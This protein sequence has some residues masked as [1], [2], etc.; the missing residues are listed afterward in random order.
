MVYFKQVYAINITDGSDF[1]LTEEYLSNNTEKYKKILRSR[2]R[3]LILQGHRLDKVHFKHRRV[4]GRFTLNTRSTERARHK[5][6][7]LL[8][9][10]GLPCPHAFFGGKIS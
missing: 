2:E 3:L 5:L 1:Y 8:R 7:R 4:W 6:L 9:Q 10:S